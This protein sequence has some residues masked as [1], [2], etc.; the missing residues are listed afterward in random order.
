MS[1]NDSRFSGKRIYKAN[2]ASAAVYDIR[3]RYIHR[4]NSASSPEYEI[5]GDRIHRAHSVSIGVQS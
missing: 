5:R 2:S 1:G 4:A 3:G